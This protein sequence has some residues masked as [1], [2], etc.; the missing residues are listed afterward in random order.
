MA[1]LAVMLCRNYFCRK[2]HFLLKIYGVCMCVYVLRTVQRLQDRGQSSYEGLRAVVLEVEYVWRPVGPFVFGYALAESD[3]VMLTM[4]PVASPSVPVSFY[5]RL[6]LYDANEIKAVNATTLA[7]THPKYPGELLTFDASTFLLAPRAFQDPAARL[8]TD[9]DALSVQAIHAY[10]N[11]PPTEPQGNPGLREDGVRAQVRRLS[12]VD[13]YWVG[14]EKQQP[15]I[16]W[17]YLGTPR[18]VFRRYPVHLSYISFFIAHHHHYCSYYYYC[19][20]W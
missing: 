4:K 18:G 2:S 19:L 8:L 20:G 12:S 9:D 17:L 11:A 15:A 5:H 14:A 13:Q 1:L 16:G 7:R 6:A 10:V 3:R